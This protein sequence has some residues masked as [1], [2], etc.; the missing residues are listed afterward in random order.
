MRLDQAID[1]FPRRDDRR[2]V[3]LFLQ[4]AHGSHRLAYRAPTHFGVQPTDEIVRPVCR[5]FPVL[6]VD[7]QRHQSRLLIAHDR[8]DPVVEQLERLGQRRLPAWWILPA[9]RLGIPAARKQLRHEVAL[10]DEAL[11]ELA[12]LQNRK[13]FFGISAVAAKIDPSER[14]KAAQLT[15]RRTQTRSCPFARDIRGSEHRARTINALH[16]E[17]GSH[18]H[19]RAGNNAHDDPGSRRPKARK[20]IAKIDGLVVKLLW[21][22][23]HQHT[24]ARPP[25]RSRSA[26]ERGLFMVAVGPESFTSYQRVAARRLKVCGHHLLHQCSEVRLRPPT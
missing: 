11:G 16:Q 22:G 14:R 18:K 21:R 8:A 24:I 10:L 9:A 5:L 17:S 19:C 23:A 7:L 13:R 2:G 4:I 1:C 26:P 20:H 25:I 3:Q 12:G 15:E 6:P